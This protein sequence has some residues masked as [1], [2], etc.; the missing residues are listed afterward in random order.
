MFFCD[1]SYLIISLFSH[2]GQCLDCPAGTTCPNSGMNDTLPC[3][4]GHYCLNGTSNDGIN[5][6]IGKYCNFNLG[7][8]YI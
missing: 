4:A 7:I 1:S 5:C 8:P 2:K 6:P 3:P